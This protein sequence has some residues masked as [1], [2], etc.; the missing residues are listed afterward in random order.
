MKVSKEDRSELLREKIQQLVTDNLFFHGA[1]IMIE[2]LS[3]YILHQWGDKKLKKAIDEYTMGRPKR[4]VKKKLTG[5][6]GGQGD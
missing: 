4:K 6:Q 2:R 5:R 1:K 3:D